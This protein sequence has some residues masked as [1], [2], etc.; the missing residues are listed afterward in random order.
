[1]RTR[2]MAWRIAVLALAILLVGAG[3]PAVR[4]AAGG[5]A[6]GYL[7]MG[8]VI[9]VLLLAG[10]VG[11]VLGVGRYASTRPP[12]RPAPG[13]QNSSENARAA[14]ETSTKFGGYR[15]GVAA[16]RELPTYRALLVTFVLQAL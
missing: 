13:E 9:A 12:G 15:S 10:M 5:D 4:D 16:L 3:G 1:E 6:S 7:T 11:T 8:L 14:D 2:L